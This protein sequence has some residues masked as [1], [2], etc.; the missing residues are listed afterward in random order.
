[1]AV[2][3]NSGIF[4][5]N[6]LCICEILTLHIA[7]INIFIHYFKCIMSDLQLTSHETDGTNATRSSVYELVSQN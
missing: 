5:V 3:G 4:F 2:D 6:S 7:Y 1:M